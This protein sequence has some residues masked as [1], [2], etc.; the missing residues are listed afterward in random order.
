MEYQQRCLS[1]RACSIMCVTSRRVSIVMVIFY[2]GASYLVRQGIVA[3]LYFLACCTININRHFVPAVLWLGNV[4]YW[5]APGADFFIGRKSLV[6]HVPSS[7][8]VASLFKNNGKLSTFSFLFAELEFFRNLESYRVTYQP[9]V[10][11]STGTLYSC[12][13]GV[14]SYINNFICQTIHSMKKQ[15]GYI[16]VRAVVSYYTP[17]SLVWITSIVVFPSMRAC[18]QCHIDNSC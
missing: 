18:V 12:A 17:P 10:V 2:F 11:W 6:R 7:G 9:T 1:L 16:P 4:L 15:Q 14:V 13:R 8:I 5:Y 3:T